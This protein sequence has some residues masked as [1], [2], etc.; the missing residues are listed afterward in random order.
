[1]TWKLQAIT[2]E[3]TG[4]EISIDRDMLVGRHQD[5][6]L[7]LQAAEISRRHAALLLKDQLLWVQ[8]LNSS[9]GTFINDIRIEQEKQLHDGDIVQFASFKFSVLA[10]AQENN[11]L[12]EIEAEPVQAAPAQDLS[13]Q[14]MPSL[15]ERAAEVEVRHDGMPQNISI[16]KPAPI[17]EGVNIHAQPEQTPVAI[18]EPVS[19]V[20]EEKEQQKNASIGLIT[21]IILVILAVLAWLFFK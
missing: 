20:A 12:P 15:A 6:D 19:R 21:I 14:G 4:Q 2:G 7:L 9:N 3:F 17:P 13:D 11:D 16:P 10:P 8:D 5:A 18:E 1:M